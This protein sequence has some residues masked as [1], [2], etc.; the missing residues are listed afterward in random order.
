[1]NKQVV[2]K[3]KEFKNL[4]KPRLFAKHNRSFE[5]LETEA[6]DNGRT[7]AFERSVVLYKDG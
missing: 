1:V 2:E 7:A 3:E 5:A 6:L 4:F